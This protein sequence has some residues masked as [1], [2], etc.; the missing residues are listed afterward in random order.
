[1]IRREG[2]EDD[3]AASDKERWLQDSTVYECISHIFIKIDCTSHHMKMRLHGEWSMNESCAIFDAG[4][5][6][7]IN[8]D[9]NCWNFTDHWDHK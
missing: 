5:K 1:M 3:G 7:A 8:W 4:T 6:W 2:K 9:E